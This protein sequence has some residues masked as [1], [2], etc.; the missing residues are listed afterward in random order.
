MAS[1]KNGPKKFI[2]RLAEIARRAKPLRSLVSRLGGEA[3]KSP[4]EL[5]DLAAECRRMAEKAISLEVRE[6]FLQAADCW[7]SLA[8]E[9]EAAELPKSARSSN[10]GRGRLSH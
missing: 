5:R 1:A 4:K 10:G 9:D 7:L 6:V 8:D 2:G 3:M